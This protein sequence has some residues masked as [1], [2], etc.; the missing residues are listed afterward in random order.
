MAVDEA[1]CISQWGHDFR[2]DYRLLAP[3][4]AALGAPVM[5]LTATAEPAV[6]ATLAQLLEMGKLEPRGR[7]YPTVWLRG[8]PLRASPAGGGSR[9]A[10][11]A[12]SL[13][14]ALQAFSR[15][16]AR[17]LGWRPYMVL[18]R[19]SCR[20]VVAAP[21]ASLWALEQLPGIG[22]SMVARFGAVL[23]AL[24]AKFVAA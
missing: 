8:R 23:L 20:A 3:L 10:R 11:P 15:R 14:R 6:Q 18:S 5:A 16:Q 19:A 7:K 24:V 4:C 2:P 9:R 17:Q 1:H 12:P 21:P 13:E 22:P